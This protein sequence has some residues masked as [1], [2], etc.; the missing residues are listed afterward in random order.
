MS[1]TTLF[2]IR[3]TWSALRALGNSCRQKFDSTGLSPDV[4]KTESP[5]NPYRSLLLGVLLA[6]GLLVPLGMGILIAH[7]SAPLTGPYGP[8]VCLPVT[9][10]VLTADQRLDAEESALSASLSPDASPAWNDAEERDSQLAFLSSRPGKFA[11]EVSD[12]GPGHASD[13]PMHAKG[14]RQQGLVRFS[15]GRVSIETVDGSILISRLRQAAALPPTP[16]VDPLDI[17]LFAA[18]GDS[19][20]RLPPLLYGET[21]GPDGNPVRW[22]W[23]SGDYPQ[24][25][26][27]TCD[28]SEESPS[29]RRL[30]LGMT[31]P[32]P[33]VYYGL[34]AGKYRNVVSL[35][36]EKY[37]LAAALML[38]IMHTESNFNP[39]AVSPN[40]AVGLMQIV[41]DTAGNE[42][43]RFLMGTQGTPSMETLFSPEDNI[44]YG[45]I[46]LHLLGRRYFGGVANTASR[47]L[48]IIA[49]Y[50]CGPNAVLRLFD[51]NQDAAVDR[52]NSLTPEQVYSALT[53]DMPSEQTRRYVEVVMSR[54]RSYSAN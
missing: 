42:V 31:I 54:L 33:G 14:R 38:A 5:A 29:I 49:A 15:K 7:F 17:T 6:A 28:F 48:C 44:K 1:D 19:Q 23:R 53:T 21:L 36:A 18:A 32:V 16:A 9:L 20:K 30:L 47:Q 2:P 43:Y 50:N 34:N 8:Y 22:T 10:T 45:A 3:H 35:Y 12:A 40:Q 26:I 46:Y 27:K 39:F 24:K 25:T 41:P 13:L 51:T 11:G 37:D 4:P 52:I